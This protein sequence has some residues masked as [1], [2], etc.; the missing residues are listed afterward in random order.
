M[1]SSQIPNK[2]N[3]KSEIQTQ[4]HI[5]DSGRHSNSEEDLPYQVPLTE[6]NRLRQI[7]TQYNET[8][9]IL[10]TTSLLPKRRKRKP[11]IQERDQVL[12]HSLD[13]IIDLSFSKIIHHLNQ[14]PPSH[15]A[16]SR[17]EESKSQSPR[18]NEEHYSKSNGSDYECQEFEN[19]EN[20][21]LVMANEK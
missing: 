19:E 13:D 11:I 15:L 17:G 21:Y 5:Q 2:E 4:S 3:P 10:P 7:T 18:I 9:G 20:I 14:I 6:L 8:L 12:A 1:V 16:T